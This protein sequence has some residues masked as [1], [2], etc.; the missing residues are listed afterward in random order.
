M[1]VG[2]RTDGVKEE[3]KDVDIS[4]AGIKKAKRK[5]RWPFPAPSAF[6]GG[7]IKN[8]GPAPASLLVLD[9]CSAALWGGPRRVHTELTSKGL[10]TEVEAFSVSAAARVTTRREAEILFTLAAGARRDTPA[11]DRWLGMATLAR[12][13][14]AAAEAPA[15]AREEAMRVAVDM[16]RERRV[17]EAACGFGRVA[18]RGARR[19]LV[20]KAFALPAS[21]H[22]RLTIQCSF[23]SRWRRKRTWPRQR[24]QIPPHGVWHVFYV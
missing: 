17:R 10:A 14:E 9:R 3:E 13:R 7:K 2:G 16:L 5:V 12:V 20:T 24:R 18:Q 8:N 4:F 6:F 19:A 23:A 22:T 11:T 21:E 1:G 15:A